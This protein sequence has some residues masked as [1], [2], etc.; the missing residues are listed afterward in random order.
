MAVDAAITRR[1]EPDELECLLVEHGLVV[2]GDG[3]AAVERLEDVIV[4]AEDVG[5]LEHRH[6]RN[7]RRQRG[8]GDRSEVDGAKLYLLGNLALAAEC[9]GMM[10][11]DLDLAAAQRGEL[12]DELLGGLRRAVLGRID[13][14][15]A[16]LLR[17]SRAR[18]GQRR[19]KQ[20]R[21][22]SRAER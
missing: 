19:H 21:V 4:V 17:L 20:Q 15:E 9:A 8:R 11:D 22:R 5:Q 10:M 12:V 13:V 7:Q 3:V 16:Q 2:L 14:A 1:D 6:L 18:A